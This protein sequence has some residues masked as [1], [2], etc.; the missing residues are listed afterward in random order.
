MQV[1]DQG[2]TICAENA[3]GL[4]RTPYIRRQNGN[5]YDVFRKVK[6]IFDPAGLLNPGKI[7]GDDPEW[8]EDEVR[9][10]LSRLEKNVVRGRVLA[11][12][13]RIDGR[14]HKTVRPIDVKV[15]VLPRAHGSAIF[16]Q[17][18]KL[19]GLLTALVA[20][21]PRFGARVGDFDAIGF[22][23]RLLFR[24]GYLCQRGRCALLLLLACQL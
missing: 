4:S 20:H 15:G 5:L 12:E 18:I 9:G 22:F 6:D 16:T 23:G 3:C 10:A 24:L 2:G 19:P 8:S 14:D 11:G 1:L 17:D 21:P 7:V 13:P